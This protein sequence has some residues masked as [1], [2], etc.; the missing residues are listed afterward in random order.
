M[1]ARGGNRRGERGMDRLLCKSSRLR[2]S[3]AL[4]L[5]MSHIGDVMGPEDWIRLKAFYP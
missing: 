3:T 4:C 2:G 5:P 1:P